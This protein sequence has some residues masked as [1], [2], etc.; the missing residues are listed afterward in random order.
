MSGPR[1]RTE[2]GLDVIE[3]AAFADR[4]A[5]VR[6]IRNGLAR[7]ARLFVPTYNSRMAI[8]IKARAPTR[9]DARRE[10]ARLIAPRRRSS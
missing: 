9:P 3:C 6:A 5:A 7:T 1:F 2:W 4:L 8:R 10:L